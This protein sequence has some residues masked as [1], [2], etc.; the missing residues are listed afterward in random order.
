MSAWWVKF[1]TGPIA[2]DAAAQA[3]PIV[4]CKT[5]QQVE[6]DPAAMAARYGAET[7]VPDWRERLVCSATGPAG[8]IRSSAGTESGGRQPI[9]GCNAGRPR[10]GAQLGSRRHLIETTAPPRA[11]HP[12]HRTR[13]FRSST[14]D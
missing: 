7:P 12:R 8:S 6:P 10:R 9:G 14:L 1:E 13:V 11:P 5:C 4:W 2:L 3:R